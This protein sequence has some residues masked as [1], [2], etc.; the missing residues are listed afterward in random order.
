[1]VLDIRMPGR[2]GLDFQQDMAASHKEIP[3]VLITAHGDI[4]MSVRAMKAGAIEFLAKP[5]REQDLLDAIH[6]GL[7]QARG[8]REAAAADQDLL[9][10]LA[11]LSNRERQVMDL[12]AGGQLTKQVA[13]ALGLSEI[14]IKLCRASM[15]RKLGAPSLIEL[16]RI[17]ERVGA[18]SQAQD[19]L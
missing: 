10:R 4:P 11:S 6:M 3:I 12:V 15:M 2:N 1:M 13:A 14:T 9:Q 16:G 18:I 5:F 19:G 8:R 17:V 7:A